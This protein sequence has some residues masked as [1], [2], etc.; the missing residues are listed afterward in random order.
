MHGHGGRHE[1]GDAD[2]DAG[3]SDRNAH[4]N[5]DGDTHCYADG[6]AAGPDIQPDAHGHV[7]EQRY[8]SSGHVDRHAHRYTHIDFHPEHYCHR[9]YVRDPYFDLD[10]TAEC[11]RHADRVGNSD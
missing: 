5:F 3:R 7:D 6:D 10:T 8:G 2:T 1:L 9:R 4:G 11:D